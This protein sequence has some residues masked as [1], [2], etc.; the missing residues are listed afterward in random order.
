VAD[1]N[2]ATSVK[3]E[4]LAA[5]VPWRTPTSGWYLLSSEQLTHKEN[6]YFRIA[7]PESWPFADVALFYVPQDEH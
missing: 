2:V 4:S 1:L 6:M 3:R 5:D 7:K